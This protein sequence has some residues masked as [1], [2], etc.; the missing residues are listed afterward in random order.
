MLMNDSLLSNSK[1]GRSQ[2][3]KMLITLESHGIF[4]S[5]GQSVKMLI[6]LESHGIFGSFL[7]NYF[8]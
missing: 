8:F 3:V 4:A 6:T 2:T 5:R 1:V 7:H